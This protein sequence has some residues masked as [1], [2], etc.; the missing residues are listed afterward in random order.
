MSNLTELMPP[1]IWLRQIFDAKSARDGGIVRRKTKDV[2]RIVG[3]TALEMELRRRG[4]HAV[5]NAG[6]I[7]IFCNNAPVKVIS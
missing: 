4:F 5:E 7:V 2:E 1:Q 6:Q 3:R